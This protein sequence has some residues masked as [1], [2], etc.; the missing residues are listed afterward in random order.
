MREVSQELFAVVR[1]RGARVS[2][3]WAREAVLGR[4]ARSF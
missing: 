4:T 2:V 1:S 3:V